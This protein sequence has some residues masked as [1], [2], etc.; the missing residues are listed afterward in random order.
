MSYVPHRSLTTCLTAILI[1][2]L[3]PMA[4]AQQ[5]SAVEHAATQATAPAGDPYTL[6]VDP[7]TGDKL[8]DITQQIIVDHEG[9]E[10]R[11]GTQ[12]S[13]EQFK[14]D[15]GQY[16]PSVD[17]QIVQQQLP[18]YPLETCV[19]SGKTL[20]GEM[21]EPINYVYKNRLVRLCCTMCKEAFTKGPTAY[22]GELDEAV[23][24]QQAD[25]YPLET[26]PVSGMELGGAMGDPV[27]VVIANRLVRLCSEGCI[28]KLRAD[29][30]KYL[31]SLDAADPGGG[32]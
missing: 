2:F 6:G 22:L 15:P 5:D 13:A 4:W 11:F 28:S 31:G 16:L 30:G 29:P 7:V 1:A 21:G 17:E 10:L 23:K 14:K 25:D 26:C 27:E 8:P 19:V 32:T 18:Y 20:G 12:E 9:R 3:S 24:R